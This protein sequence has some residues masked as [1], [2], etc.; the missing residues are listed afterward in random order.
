MARNRRKTLKK[1]KEKQK[2]RKR[3]I[4]AINIFVLLLFYRETTIFR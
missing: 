3:Q 2:M 4:K 1:E